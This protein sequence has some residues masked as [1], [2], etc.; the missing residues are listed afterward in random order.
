MTALGQL[1]VT[2]LRSYQCL[3]GKDSSFDSH[4]ARASHE[5]FVALAKY[6]LKTITDKVNIRGRIDTVAK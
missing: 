6:F 4:L 5:D 1:V 3:T 2:L